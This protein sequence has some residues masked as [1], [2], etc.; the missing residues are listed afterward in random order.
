MWT[1]EMKSNFVIADSESSI[2][3]I[4]CNSVDG[5]FSLLSSIDLN[6]IVMTVH[7]FNST[8]P[9]PTHHFRLNKMLLAATFY[10]GSVL[11]LTRDYEFMYLNESKK[12]LNLLPAVRP[13]INQ[14]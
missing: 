1:I 2:F 3:A 13:I 6:T 7:I 5:N 12:L 8:S 11:V 9:C 4:I 14:T 10:N